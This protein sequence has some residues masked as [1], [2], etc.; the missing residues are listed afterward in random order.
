MN[1]QFKVIYSCN[2]KLD[3]FSEK[4]IDEEYVINLHDYKSIGTHW[5]VLYI[6]DDY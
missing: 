1:H 3:N 5:I 2:C 4:I 6:N